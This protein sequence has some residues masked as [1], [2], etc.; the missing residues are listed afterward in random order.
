M[1]FFSLVNDYTATNDPAIFN[2]FPKLFQKFVDKQYL[3]S[4]VDA[5]HDTMA[6]KY[7]E[8][9]ATTLQEYNKIDDSDNSIPYQVY[10][11]LAWGGLQEAPI[12]KTKFS[13]GSAEYNRIIGRYNGESV[14]S[15]INGEK[16]IGKP[17]VIK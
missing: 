14:N 15:T 16:A 13:E 4:K 7:V 3:G 2:D 10:E 12:F 11:D 5:Y 8:A 9:I 17:C 1:L 6:N